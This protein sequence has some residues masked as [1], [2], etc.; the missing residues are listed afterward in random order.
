MNDEVWGHRDKRGD[1]HPKELV[2]Y[3]PAPW[4]LVKFI[5]WLFGLPGYLLPWTLAYIVL[6]ALL[7]RYA[8]PAVVTMQTLSWQSVALVLARNLAVV[9]VIYGAWHYFLYVRRTQGQRFKLNGRWPTVD[10]DIFLF[11]RQTPDNVIWSLASG[12]PVWT[13][14]EVFGYWMF[15]NDYVTWVR[16]SDTPLLFTA[17]LLAVPVFHDLHFYLI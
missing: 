4:R 1:W 8:T 13:A 17:V 11:K 6:S 10:N 14:W 7:W 15:A 16:F 9:A 2:A 5:R 12:V 3:P